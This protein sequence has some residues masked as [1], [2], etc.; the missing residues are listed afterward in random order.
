VT[1][2][3]PR[4][5]KIISTYT[6]SST[7]IHCACNR[8]AK[9]GSLLLLVTEDMKIFFLNTENLT[10]IRTLT[11]SYNP[12][13]RIKEGSRICSCDFSLSDTTFFGFSDGSIIK[14]RMYEDPIN[15]IHD[16]LIRFKTS[17]DEFENIK[18]VFSTDNNFSQEGHYSSNGYNSRSLPESNSVE[19]ILV[20]KRYK[21]LFA[22]Q[23]CNAGISKINSFCLRNNTFLKTFTKVENAI[24][25]TISLIDKRDLIIIILFNIESKQTTLELWSYQDNSCAMTSY[26]M[27]PLLDYPFTIKTLHSTALPMKFVG[28]NSNHGTLDGDIVFLPTTKGDII[29]GKVYTLFTNNKIGFEP[30]YIYKLKNKTKIG[31]EMSNNFEISFINYDLYFDVLMI[32]DVSSNVRFFEKI[33]HIGKQST[34]DENLPFF[35]LFY[36]GE[37]TSNRKNSTKAEINFDLPVFSINHD[38]LKDR[39]VIMYDQGKDL[40]ISIVEEETMDSSGIEENNISPKA[41][42]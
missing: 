42:K 5:G 10:I 16:N 38:V 8:K 40:T 24:V 37:S 25:N 34:I 14:C 13:L 28:R 30:V 32:G 12:K 9:D 21:T 15:L 26:L 2:F 6:P 31:D 41:V 4:S 35:S 3:A 7:I 11:L 33:L 39:S 27:N 29:V 23:K 22:L 20:S 36:E 17:E 18:S 19:I 1:N